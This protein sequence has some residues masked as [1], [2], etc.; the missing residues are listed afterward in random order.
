VPPVFA[1]N[2]ASPRSLACLDHVEHGNVSRVAGECISAVN[3]GATTTRPLWQVVGG[4]WPML[5][6]ADHRIRPSHWR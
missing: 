4:S 6:G 3:P 1:V 2:T 5:H